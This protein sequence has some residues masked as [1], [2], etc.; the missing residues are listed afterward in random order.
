M[1]IQPYGL[2]EV[3][4]TRSMKKEHLEKCLEHRV[5]PARVLTVI[6]MI[7]KVAEELDFDLSQSHSPENKGP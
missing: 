4:V 6:F 5:P 3:D 7:V 2:C 1:G